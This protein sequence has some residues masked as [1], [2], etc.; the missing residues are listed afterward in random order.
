MTELDENT[1]F[2]KVIPSGVDKIVITPKETGVEV[3]FLKI[4]STKGDKITDA[5]IQG[6]LEFHN[7]NALK[8]FRDKLT[9]EIKCVE[10]TL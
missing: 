5:Y 4:T 1:K 10:D 9:E 2:H 6:E 8:G 7:L 3:R